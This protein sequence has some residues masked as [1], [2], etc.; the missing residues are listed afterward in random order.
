MRLKGYFVWVFLCAAIAS[1]LLI[2][3]PPGALRNRATRLHGH[4]SPDFLGARPAPTV[5]LGNLPRTPCVA[6]A[7]CAASF[8]SLSMA[9]EANLGQAAPRVAFIER[10]QG[11][12]LLLTREGIE[13]MLEPQSRGEAS[14]TVKIRFEEGTVTAGPIV[15][16]DSNQSAPQ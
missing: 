9:M 15:A 7:D 16:S 2:G 11:S 13:V 1:L 14:R 5:D 3:N 4:S 8:L 12:T 6:G 10:G